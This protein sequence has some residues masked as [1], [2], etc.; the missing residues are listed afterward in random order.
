M[1][2]LQWWW[3][4]WS[5]IEMAE[6]TAYS[7]GFDAGFRAGLTDLGRAKGTSFMAGFMEGRESVKTHPLDAPID[8]EGDPLCQ[9]H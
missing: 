7:K 3:R 5:G 9:S 2:R 1:T 6:R 8:E 4:Q